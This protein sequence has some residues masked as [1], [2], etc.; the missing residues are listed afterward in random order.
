MIG[1][2]SE[3][4]Q[5]LSLLGDMTVCNSPLQSLETGMAVR[6]QRSLAASLG[7]SLCS[8]FTFLASGVRMT[9]ATSN[10]EVFSLVRNR[11]RWRDTTPL[12]Y[13][14]RYRDLGGNKVLHTR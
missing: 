3:V 6:H 12:G 7:P 11:E 14:G 9:S 10:D 5:G 4:S 8:F 13:R 1:A 2:A